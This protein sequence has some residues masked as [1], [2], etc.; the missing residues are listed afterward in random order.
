VRPFQIRSAWRACWQPRSQPSG[1]PAATGI[2]APSALTVSGPAYA[3]DGL[4]FNQAQIGGK[5]VTVCRV[6]LRK[7]PLQLFLRDE[8]GQP[9]RRFD[10]LV[11]MLARRGERLSFAVN[12]GMYHTDFSP[13][14]LFVTQQQ[15]VHPLNTAAGEGNFFLKPNGVFVV[16][17]AGASVVES[18]EYPLLRNR[19]LLATQSGPLL[20]RNGQ[21]HPAFNPGSASRH[22]R[23]GVGVPAPDTV[24]FAIAEEPVTFHEFA[25]LFR[26]DLHCPDALYLDGTVSSLF[27]PELKRNDSKYNLGPMLGITESGDPGGVQTDP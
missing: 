27:A 21:L 12:A 3:R 25:R 5:R 7:R 6:N 19:V 14:G 9:L 22:V 17:E 8:S 23:N 11:T 24:V 1:W 18:S 10:S 26:D 2:P 15:E 13:V 4:E 20:V 16:T